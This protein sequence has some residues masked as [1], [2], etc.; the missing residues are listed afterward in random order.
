[1]ENRHGGLSTALDS[2]QTHIAG[3]HVLASKQGIVRPKSDDA[4]GHNG[5]AEQLM[6]WHLVMLE[7]V[8]MSKGRNGSHSSLSLGQVD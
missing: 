1:M 8:G 4:T 2:F 3:K 5:D 6:T 7:I